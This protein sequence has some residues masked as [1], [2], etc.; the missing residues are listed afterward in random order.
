MQVW[1]HSHTNHSVTVVHGVTCAGAER[2][3]RVQRGTG[4]DRAQPTRPHEGGGAANGLCPL[5]AHAA[6]GDRASRGA[7]RRLLR[8]P[9][10]PRRPPGDLQVRRLYRGRGVWTGWLFL[11]VRGGWTGGPAFRGRGGRTGGRFQ[12]ERRWTGGPVLEREGGLVGLL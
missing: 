12:R 9:R 4:V 11:V 10:R 3:G 8:R 2:A 7:Q 1:R 5:P 6:R